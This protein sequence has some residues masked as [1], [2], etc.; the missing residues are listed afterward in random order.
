MLLHIHIF[1][2]LFFRSDNTSTRNIQMIPIEFLKN[3]TKVRDKVRLEKNG[4]SKPLVHPY[5]GQICK[6]QK[7]K[8][9]FL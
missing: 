2:K 5:V 3:S 4:L 1:D 7:T 8:K 9:I 6:F